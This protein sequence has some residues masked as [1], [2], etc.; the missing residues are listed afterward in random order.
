[1]SGARW[2]ALPMMGVLA[3]A[4]AEPAQ[5]D[6]KDLK[7][8]TEPGQYDRDGKKFERGLYPGGKNDM[9]EA[10]RTAGERLART[11]LPLG[12]GK[13]DPQNGQVLAVAIGHSNPKRYFDE[14]GSFLKTKAQQGEVSSRFVLVNACQGGKLCQDWAAECRQGQLKVPRPAEVQVLFVLVTYHR[15]NR[16]ATQ[17]KNPEVLT[18]PF[19]KKMLRMK[20]ELKLILQ[21]AVKTCPNLKLAYL[22]ADTWRGNASLEPE[23]YEEAFAIQWLIADQLRGEADL[24][25]DGPQRKVPWLAWGGYIWEANAPRDRFVGDGVHPSDKGTAFVVNRW[26]EA[27]AK[28]STARPWFVLKAPAR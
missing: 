13:P 14:F 18:T 2:I 5:P 7:P 3:L 6:P 19:E 22:G 4:F 23:V 12:N 27:L 1:M 28:D 17:T 8:L 16:N 26:Y 9:P 15:A 24:A 21:T 20:E 11:I 10:H 25:F